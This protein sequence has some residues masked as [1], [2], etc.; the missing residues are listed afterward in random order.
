MTTVRGKI[1]LFKAV[2]VSTIDVQKNVE[3]Q[4]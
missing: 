3:Y 4:L 2:K 1:A